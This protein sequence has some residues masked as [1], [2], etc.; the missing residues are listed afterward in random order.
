MRA[1]AGSPLIA[2]AGR[3]SQGTGTQTLV[4][5]VLLMADVL[6][7]VFQADEATEAT[8]EALF[9]LRLVCKAWEQGIALVVHDEAWLRPL[10]ASGVVFCA[11]MLPLVNELL[12]MD[13][14]EAGLQQCWYFTRQ[15]RAHLYDANTQVCAMANLMRL[16]EDEDTDQLFLCDYMD[17]I[18]RALQTHPDDEKVHLQA[19][20]TISAFHVAPETSQSMLQ[21]GIVDH[22]LRLLGMHRAHLH[23]PASALAAL[24]RLMEGARATTQAVAK[25][26]IVALVCDV[27]RHGVANPELMHSGCLFV[28]HLANASYGELLQQGRAD[29]LVFHSMQAFPTRRF[30]QVFCLETLLALV[31]GQN[32]QDSTRVAFG[33]ASRGLGLVL[34]SLDTICFHPERPAWCE[35]DAVCTELLHKL[36]QCDAR[37]R[38]GMVAGGVVP[39]LVAALAGGDGILR[40]ETSRRDA[41]GALV[42]LAGERRHRRAVASALVMPAIV[43]AMQTQDDV[44]VLLCC[45]LIGHLSRPAARLGKKHPV[46]PADAVSTVVGAL[47]H[48]PGN[49]H[50]QEA[51]VR[52]LQSM[53]MCRHNVHEVSRCGGARVLMAALGG[54]VMKH[55]T[56][57]N[58]CV[59]LSCLAG[60][61]AAFL[62]EASE[63]HG[64]VVRRMVELMDNSGLVRVQ[65][66]AL[67]VFASLVAPY[68]HMHAVFR[69]GGAA[70]RVQTLLTKQ[71]LSAKSRAVGERVLRTC[72][73]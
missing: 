25:T 42:Q 16:V 73:P 36:S 57:H 60:T 26:E 10:R 53:L 22:V 71:G 19:C 31:D 6:S 59:A 11:E 29:T 15:V 46:A 2:R 51:G 48:F 17:V 38:A 72:A 18:F 55:A 49:V 44:T 21:T 41:L 12:S 1:A 45:R 67:G 4:L 39:R 70:Q 37:A 13:Q 62:Q 27:V 34:Q 63:W 66:H 68:A 32:S 14:N 40:T 20:I 30:V 56:V 64:G 35:A 8:V 54:P 65:S 61:D 69:E 23:I 7:R 52:A 33:A 24:C 5:H 43:A 9:G 3:L 28:Q 50:I 58:A 47:T